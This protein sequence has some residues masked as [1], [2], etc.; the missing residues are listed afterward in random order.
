MAAP[1][2]E[3]SND[4]QRTSDVEEEEEPHWINILYLYVPDLANT[5]LS[6]AIKD[7]MMLGTNGTEYLILTPKRVGN[8][9]KS[10]SEV[11]HKVYPTS[12]WGKLTPCH[13]E[14]PT[15]WTHKSTIPPRRGLAHHSNRYLQRE[16]MDERLGAFSKVV[17]KYHKCLLEWNANQLMLD[18]NARHKEEYRLETLMLHISSRI[19]EILNLLAKDN[20]LH[21]E[22]NKVTLTQLNSRSHHMN[23]SG[24]WQV[25]ES[26][27]W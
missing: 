10:S 11:C 8:P 13:S 16:E 3:D 6:E 5:I 4:Q 17:M 21:K 9:K 18:T 27:I 14:G 7:G 2:P 12:I 26:T 24:S 15:K 25:W 1:Q 20:M 23:N 22:N 19:D